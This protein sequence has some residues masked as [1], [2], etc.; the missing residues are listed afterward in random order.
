MFY[1][2]AARFVLA[3]STMKLSKPLTP[4]GQISAIE[5]RSTMLKYGHSRGLASCQP[6]F[7]PDSFPLSRDALGRRFPLPLIRHNSFFTSVQRLYRKKEE[8]ERDNRYIHREREKER[9]RE[10]ESDQEDQTKQRKGSGTQEGSV[11]NKRRSL[12]PDDPIEEGSKPL[13]SHF[14]AFCAH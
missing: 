11:V 14:T 13:N 7:S 4:S 2:R 3:K 9:N 8:R 12:T 1:S 10:R 6:G 5:R